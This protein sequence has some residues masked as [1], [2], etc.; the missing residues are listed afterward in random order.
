MNSHSGKKLY[1]ES[2][3]NSQMGGSYRSAVLYAQHLLKIFKP[4]SVADLGCGRGTWLKAFGENGVEKLV[5]LDG[6]WNSQEK[7][8]DQ[9]VTFSPVDL[10]KPFPKPTERFDL[11][12]SVEVAEHLK[13][14]SSK[15]FVDNITALSDVV[16]F[17]AAYTKQGGT[18][19]INEQPH[20]YWAKMFI[21]I[22]YTPYDVFRSTFWGNQDIEFW[23]QQNTFLFQIY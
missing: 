9:T 4:Q 12:I 16:M 2:Y 11:A 3:F 8:V 13:E 22:G 20:T 10:N 1:G 15:T 14:E 5:G 23:Y 19:H 21:E 7:M 17:G 18:D 6:D